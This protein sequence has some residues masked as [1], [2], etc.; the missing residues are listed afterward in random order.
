MR[1]TGDF[2]NV[3]VTGGRNGTRRIGKVLRAVFRPDTYTLAGYLVARPDLLFMFK[4]K[5][6]FLAWDAFRVVDGR[7]VATIDRDSWDEPAC[8]RLG[9]DW[10]T[11]LILEGMPLVTS[12]GDKVGNID[13]VEYDERS[14]RL[15]ALRVGDGMAAK[16]L[17]GTSKVPADLVVGYRDGTMVAERAASGI[18]SEGGLAAKAGEQTAVATQAIK[19]KT[20]R[21]RKAASKMGKKAGAAADKALDTGSRALGKQL[22]RTRG[23]FKGFRDEYRKGRGK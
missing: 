3:R 17:I 18:A 5:D 21:A 19:E 22:G 2:R 11:C 9:I 13:A 1:S 8:K 23:M 14:G 20:D 10:D 6:R 16:A 15:V 12:D 4:R 7:V